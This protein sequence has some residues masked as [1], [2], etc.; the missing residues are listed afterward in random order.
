MIDKFD[1][2]RYEEGS[3]SG[4]FDFFKIGVMKACLKLVGK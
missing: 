2:G 3:A 4:R 1:I